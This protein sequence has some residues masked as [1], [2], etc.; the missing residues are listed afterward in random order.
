[1]RKTQELEAEVLKYSCSL[2]A[3][4]REQASATQMGTEGAHFRASQMGIY[5]K[6]SGI[7]FI[8]VMGSPCVVL[9]GLALP[10]SSDSHSAS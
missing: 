5:K 9:T 10:G 4:V 8:F 2:C 3:G 1:M 7:Y 6:L